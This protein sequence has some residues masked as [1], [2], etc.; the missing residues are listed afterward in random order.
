[1]AARPDAAGIA[2]AVFGW[3]LA[4]LALLDFEHF[5]L[6]DALVFPLGLIGLGLGAA[7]FDPSLFDRMTGALAG[8]L[9]LTFIAWGYR[10][11]RGRVGMGQGDAKLLAAIGAWL[12]WR[13]LPWVVLIAALVGL[14]WCAVAFAMGRRVALTDRLPLGTLLAIAAWPCWLAAPPMW[15]PGM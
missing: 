11:L 8:F 7:G 10:Q 2:G 9:V 4:T 14:G 3:L 6:P 15:H 13:M 12:G 1:M 5:W